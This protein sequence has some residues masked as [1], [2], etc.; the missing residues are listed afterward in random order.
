[1]GPVD[2]QEVRFG[3]CRVWEGNGQ[4]LPQEHKNTGCELSQCKCLNGDL[5]ILLVGSHLEFNDAAPV[6]WILFC[7][8]NG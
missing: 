8:W 6:V 2:I 7:P 3:R 1:M 5:A 4:A